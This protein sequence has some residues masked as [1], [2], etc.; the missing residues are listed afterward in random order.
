MLLRSQI[1]SLLIVLSITFVAMTYAVQAL[2]V[3]PA[4]VELERQGVD[5]DINRCLD[6]LAREI[7]NLS[8]IANDWSAW[9]DSYQYV[10]D[11]N[12]TFA[13]GNLVDEAFSSTHINLI[14]IIDNERKLAWGESRDMKTLELIDVPDLIE[15]LLA[16]SSPWTRHKNI[17]DV[18]TGI[19][20]TSQGPILLA[21][22][23][24]ITTKREGPIAGTVIMGRFLNA[25]EIASLAERTKSSLHVWAVTAEMPFDA[26]EALRDCVS[27]GKTMLRTIDSRLLQAYS[28]VNDIEGSPAILLKVNVPRDISAQGRVS[29]NVATGCSIVGGAMTLL[30]MWATLQ[31][32]IVGPLQRMANHAVRI[33]KKDDLKARLGFQRGDEIG[34]LARE[35]DDMVQHLSD[36]RKKVLDSAHRAGMAEIASEVL[37]NVGNAVNSANC[38]VELLDER[39]GRSKV[40]GL[41]RAA[42][43]LREQVPNAADFFGKDPRGAK[44]VEYIA[45]LSTNLQTE[46]NENQT[47][48]S[49]LRETIRHIRDA[50]SA[51]QSY[52][53]RSNFKQEVELS[54]LVDEALQMNQEFIRTSET[55]VTIDLPP[56]PELLLN[57]SKMIQ[58]LVNLIRNA[59]QSMQATSSDSRILKISAQSVDESGIE[60]EISDT[61][62]GFSE[63]VRSQLFT[64]GF[65]TR[66]DGNGFGLHYCANAIR[67]SGGA[68][69]A[70][71]HGLGLGATFRIRLPNVIPQLV[72]S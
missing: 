65:T 39:L 53:G 49:R 56:L 20:L 58:V 25:H 29:V 47:E 5:R 18:K 13:K 50:I 71:S 16:E 37:H 48:V 54:S 62:N 30:A 15:S 19:K 34:T 11:R 44:L 33:G 23:P 4:F 67:E 46:C 26:T 55:K 31:W 45:N 42:S 66:L 60:I 61:G 36:S 70:Q 57:K 6:G 2:I 68:I 21:S 51:Q 24:M 17:D 40:G 27:T 14:C 72:A 43:L 9:D 28:V 69:S 63:E 7:D 22:R 10:Q 1:A 38:S 32:R 59:I 64:H 3:M 12:E 41:G 35:F 8:N 52:A